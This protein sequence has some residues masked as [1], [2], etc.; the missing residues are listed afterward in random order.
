MS[1]LKII[2]TTFVSFALLILLTV[3]A[4]ATAI[5]MVPSDL[6]IDTGSEVYIDIY[7]DIDEG[8]AIIAYGFDIFINGL[9]GLKLN[10]FSTGS[11]FGIDAIHQMYSDADGILGASGG[12]YFSGSAVSGENVHLG[13]LD[14]YSESPGEVTVGLTADDLNTF[15]TEGLIPEDIFLPNFMPDTPAVTIKM[16]QATPSPVPE[17]GTLLLVGIGT[18]GLAGLRKRGR[19]LK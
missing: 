7:A 4:N 5:R 8:D 17:P 12:N 11:M 6:E 16:H 18:V 14:F 10:Q 9:G 2:K 1:K 15:F 19:Q 3:S 13:R